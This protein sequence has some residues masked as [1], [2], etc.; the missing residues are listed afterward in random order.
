M[1][2]F[3]APLLLA[4]ICLISAVLLMALNYPY[5][6]FPTDEIWAY[7]LPLK[8][9]DWLASDSSILLNSPVHI[10]S[11]L[12]AK[13]ITDLLRLP[14]FQAFLVTS[15]LALSSTAF[16]LGLTV[17]AVTGR[18]LFSLG[19]TLLFV[20]SAWS[21]S[22]LHFYTYAPVAALFMMVSLYC[23][24]RY[25][26]AESRSRWLAAAS[27]L[28]V[29]LFF[30]SSSSAKLLAGILAAAYMVLTL[31]PSDR[32]KKADSLWMLAATLVPTT[33]LIPIYLRPLLSHLQ[34]NIS[35][36]NGIDCLKKYGFLPTTPFFSYFHLLGVYSTPML[37]V[38]LASL[39]IAVLQWKKILRLG[40]P[41]I[42][43]LFLLAVVLCHTVILDL[44]PFTK[45]GRT[46]FPLLPLTI[47]ALAIMFAEFPYGRQLGRWIFLG[48][49]CIAIPL[50]IDTSTRTWQ[51][52]RG[53]PDKL[54]HI[55]EPTA[56]VVLNEDPHADFITNWLQ[57]DAEFKIPLSFLPKA[58]QSR[59]TAIALIVGPTGPNSGKSILRHSIMDDFYFALPPNI[60]TMPSWTGTLP[61]YAHYPLFMMEEENSQCFFF[62]HQV[63]D[64]AA[65][66]SQ[67]KVFYWPAKTN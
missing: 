41:G 4:F 20:V 17:Q 61:Y 24:T 34:E 23:F 5:R 44:L 53:A 33:A 47:A 8:G 7:S 12:A 46:Q 43:L 19:A 58:V 59:T 13:M 28:S 63:P 55:A 49:L 14:W 56:I 48:V 51:A 67:L 57:Y 60:D 39:L 31:L 15:S 54:D 16:L 11:L 45:L 1:K 29:G 64:S 25:Y 37:L 40:R 35:A 26:L 38:L 21:Q 6:P 65:P 10:Y 32:R 66:E 42:M 30:L 22:Y 9:E 50:E 18:L 62:R 2:R 3:S 52:R 36:G 27:G